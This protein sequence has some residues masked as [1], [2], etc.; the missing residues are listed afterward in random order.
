MQAIRSNF[1]KEI[2]EGR[3]ELQARMKNIG[4]E[5]QNKSRGII[6]PIITANDQEQNYIRPRAVSE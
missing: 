1:S 3:F 5:E 4:L 6:T 2:M